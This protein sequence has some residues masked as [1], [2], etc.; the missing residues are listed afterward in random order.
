MLDVGVT[1]IVLS[2]SA[3]VYGEPAEAELDERQPRQPSNVYGVTKAFAEDVLTAYRAHGL[4]S[5][6]LRYFNAAGADRSGEIGEHHVNETHLVPIVLDAALGLR[7]AVTVF[8]T[9][10]ATHDGTCVRDY[11]HV[12]DLADAHVR[13]LDHL[14]RGGGSLQLDLGSTTGTTVREAI[15][16][17]ETVTGRRVPVRS[18]ARRTGDPARLVTSSRQAEAVLGWRAHRPDILTIVEDA[19]RWHRR[20]RTA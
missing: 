7:D 5:V 13:A 12:S 1:D 20:L 11:V 18:G 4:R 10:Y 17:A 3:A 14:R 8:G 2:S 6:A 15:A 19:W 16:A 9:D